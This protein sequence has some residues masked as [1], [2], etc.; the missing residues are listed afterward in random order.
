MGSNLWGA[1]LFRNHSA[2]ASN[3]ASNYTARC[4]GT[5]GNCD[6]SALAVINKYSKRFLNRWQAYRVRFSGH[7]RLG[8]HAR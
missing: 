7:L 6:A 8:S 4:G 2:F 3:Q 5:Q 1:G